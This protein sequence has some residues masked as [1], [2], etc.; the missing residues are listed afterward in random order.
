MI[1]RKNKYINFNKIYS[2]YLQ[3]NHALQ[4]SSPNF[5]CHSGGLILKLR[6]SLLVANLHH[7]LH[8]LTD[9]NPV[10]DRKEAPYT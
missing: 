2:S 7:E 1:S 6:G 8:N 5:L 3:A 10:D 9:F 4:N